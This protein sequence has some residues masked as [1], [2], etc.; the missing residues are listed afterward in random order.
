MPHFVKQLVPIEV[1]QA[2]DLSCQASRCTHNQIKQMHAISNTAVASKHDT[3]NNILKITGIQ[4]MSKNNDN[5]KYTAVMC[6]STSS[7]LTASSFGH[8]DFWGA[9]HIGQQQH[10]IHADQL[11]LNSFPLVRR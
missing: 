8:A 2:I 11:S 9:Q 6:V 4:V 5:V 10:S 7:W 1:Q 3:M